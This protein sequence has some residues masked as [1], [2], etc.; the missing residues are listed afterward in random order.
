MNG[1]AQSQHDFIFTFLIPAF[2]NVFSEI[3]DIL[4][5]QSNINYVNGLS[6]TNSINNQSF[7]WN[8]N[9]FYKYFSM[10]GL[11]LCDSFIQE[12][13]NVPIENFY[14]NFYKDES[15]NFTKNCQ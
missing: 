15:Q 1:S 13:Q 6:Y 7:T 5:T 8:W 11:H 12:I 3:R 10:T 14:Y 9:D 4:V 2:Q